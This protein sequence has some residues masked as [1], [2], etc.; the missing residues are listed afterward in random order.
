M[1]KR[2]GGQ[3]D[4]DAVKKARLEATGESAA[5]PR[6]T[7]KPGTGARQV[8]AIYKSLNTSYTVHNLYSI[9]PLL[10]L[11]GIIKLRVHLNAQLLLHISA[12][13]KMIPI[14]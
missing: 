8:A 4:K 10:N 6:F 13:P 5:L 11:Q 3:L 7:N 9:T 12:M 2:K 1:D 14:L